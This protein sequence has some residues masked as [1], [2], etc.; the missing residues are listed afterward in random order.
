MY[1][2]SKSILGIYCDGLLAPRVTGSSLV[3]LA[4]V[5]T[6]PKMNKDGITIHR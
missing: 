2:L 3:S 6:N 1:S 4:L 5:V